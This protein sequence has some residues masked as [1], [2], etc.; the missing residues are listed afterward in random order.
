MPLESK[1]I[2]QYDEA[3]GNS[4]RGSDVIEIERKIASS[5]D[6]WKNE[7]KTI[8]ALFISDG[9]SGYAEGVTARSYTLILSMPFAG[10]VS[11]IYGEMEAGTCTIQFKI[12]S[13]N[14]T[15]G[16]LNVTTTL[17]SSTATADN[18]FAKGDRLVLVVSA[19]SSSPEAAGL[20][21]SLDLIRQIL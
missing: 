10:V 4:F 2:H 18:V 15:G 13:T 11:K 6:K 21:F 7:K 1:R 3:P 17:A 9:F 16:S 12:G 14:I 5:P 19:P 8:S 20:N